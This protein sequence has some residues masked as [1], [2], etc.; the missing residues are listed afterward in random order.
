M[1]KVKECPK[2]GADIS[3]TY[4]VAEPDV[5]IFGS[6]WYCHTCEL[7]VDDEG[8]DSDD[9][10]RRADRAEYRNGH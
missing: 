3:D 6:G 4:E 9:Y 5:G 2:C 10:D 7:V 8:D 1:A